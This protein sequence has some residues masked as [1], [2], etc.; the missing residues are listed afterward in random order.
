MI[1]KRK[2][3]G[4]YS[5]FYMY[6]AVYFRS[7]WTVRYDNTIYGGKPEDAEKKEKQKNYSL[8]ASVIY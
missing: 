1:H 5:P 7:V 6:R 8:Q 2:R 4:G 3:A